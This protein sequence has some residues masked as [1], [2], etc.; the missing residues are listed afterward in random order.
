MGPQ[1]FSHIFKFFYRLSHG[2]IIATPYLPV[3]F[4]YGKNLKY[5]V[6]P[7]VPLAPSPSQTLKKFEVADR[8]I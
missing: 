3:P 7:G 2:G 8:L 1:G 4:K 6:T 5:G